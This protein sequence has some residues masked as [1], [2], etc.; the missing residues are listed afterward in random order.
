MARLTR[1]EVRALS[2]HGALQEIEPGVF[3]LSDA[4]DA[5]VRREA[6]ER[7]EEFL[8]QHAPVVTRNLVD[9]DCE[10]RNVRGA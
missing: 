9:R 10:V 2:A 7:G 3:A 1:C 4:G 6:A 5:R 8:A